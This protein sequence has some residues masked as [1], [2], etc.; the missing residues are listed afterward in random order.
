[1]VVASCNRF[2]SVIGVRGDRATGEKRTQLAPTMRTVRPLDPAVA[3]AYPDNTVIN[4][5]YTFYN[6]LFLSLYEQF[7]RPLNFYF[8]L[9]AC[10][11]FISVIAPVSPF[12]T[13]LPLLFAFTL[14]SL[15]EGYDD[16]KR[17]QQDDKYNNK[18]R[19]VLD[20]VSVSWQSRPNYRIRVGDV[21][22]LKG[23]EEIPC[24][25]VVVAATASTVY[26]RTDNL[27]GELDLKPREIVFPHSVS[28]NNATKDDTT[29]SSDLNLICVDDTCE[30]IINKVGNIKLV[31]PPPSAIIESFDGVAEF[32]CASGSSEDATTISVSMSHHHLLPQSC[33]LKKTKAA[34]CVAVYTG[35]ETKCGMNKSPPP[36]KW[37]KIDQDVSRYS[38]FVFFCQLASA[39]TFGL[40][41]YFLNSRV[42]EDYWYLKLPS[43]ELDASLIIY[44]LRFFLLTAVMIPVS[45]KFVV[46]MSKYYMALAV[47]WDETMKPDGPNSEGCRVKNSDILEDLGQL[48]YVLSDKTGTMTQNVME[49]LYVTIG[50]ER[51][52]LHQEI[53]E[54]VNK[55]GLGIPNNERVLHFGRILSLCNTVETLGKSG[56]SSPEGAFVLPQYQAS[57]PDEEAICRGCV[58]LH[59]QLLYRDANKAVLEVNGVKETW[60]IHHVF[61]FL[62]ELKSMGVIVEEKSTGTLYFFVK[63]ADDRIMEMAA[64]TSTPLFSTLRSRESQVDLL[65]SHLNSYARKGLRTLLVAE[66][67]L[68][69]SDLNTFMEEMR[70]AELSLQ[71]R[72]EQVQKV[73]LKM[74]NGVTIAGITA[75][76][77]KLQEGVQ[78]TVRDFIRAGIKVWMLTGDKVQTAV[79]IGLSCSLYAP[80]NRLIYIV[81]G[82]STDGVGWEEHMMSIPLPDPPK[83]TDGGLG[84]FLTGA[85]ILDEENIRGFE[86]LEDGDSLKNEVKNEN[87]Q[88]DTTPPANFQKDNS[89]LVVEGGRVLE[90]ILSTSELRA[91]FAALSDN[92]VCV[93]CAR[94]TPNQKAAL[95][96][97]V[98][99]RG[100]MTLA[101]GDGGN[102][103]AMLQEAHVGV[104]I[105][106]K[107]GQQASR[108]ADFSINRFS[109]LRALVFVHGQ[110]AYIRTA[111][112][113]K[114]S[115]Y[116]SMLISFIQ[117]A[118]NVV[119][120]YFSG[121]TFWNSFGLTVWNGVY[122]LP[123]TMFYCLDRIAPRVVLE[124]HTFL[125][126]R[127]RRASDM[128]IKEFFIVFIARG[129]VQSVLTLFLVTGV[130]NLSFA[131]S[132]TGWAATH[133]VTFSVA[134]SALIISQMLTML[135]ESH[136]ITFLNAIGIF[137]MPAFYVVMTAIY[138]SFQR[139]QYFGVWNNTMNVI[140]FLT[141]FAVAF[142]L[143]LPVLGMLSLRRAL[144]PNARDVLRTAAVQNQMRRQM[145]WGRGG[146]CSRFFRWISCVSEEAS[147]LLR[148]PSPVGPL[149][150]IVQV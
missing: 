93:I 123:Q 36:V 5:H 2:L 96:G 146:C 52:C 106:G 131:F 21:I 119:G 30:T 95:T 15:K 25:V 125:Y 118:Y 84:I 72:R 126:K 78:D 50:D 143:V 130:F 40:L 132:E 120:T 56:S 14:T 37:A 139:F 74:E 24:D 64:P 94:V 150:D 44:P 77:D 82:N 91:R 20:P 46:D 42:E 7:R 61:P 10:L 92:C 13:L 8:L 115:F 68:S 102:D 112:V 101:I 38:I 70:V 85:E 76:E 103:V 6:F 141:A 113:I 116:K 55:S 127:T 137:G 29:T 60:I 28:S 117:V 105:V 32:T 51:L 53:K 39:L 107:E 88:C 73:R 79:Q 48:D 3:A 111:F 47:E 54:L 144:T 59:V 138:S 122:T 81:S 22:L 17:H 100:F 134:Y 80:G 149:D 140:S 98:R 114:Y 90:R 69:E 33:L 11:Q 86:N 16:I 108:A 41:G 65:T 128:N 124:R 83:T 67:K 62:S 87:G 109:D 23:D 66:K 57:S 12:S 45:F 63:G 99:S 27:D 75:I 58:S 142:V 34:L 71:N 110:Q 133:D 19:T 148:H 18:A 26:I 121:G 31:I 147:C 136:S 129:I 135:L 104:G 43:N 49:L 4:S 1:M 97:F 89:V 35:E 9:V 145:R